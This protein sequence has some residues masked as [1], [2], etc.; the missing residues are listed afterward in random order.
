MLQ[1]WP[2]EVITSSQLD[3]TV[4]L[5]TTLATMRKTRHGNAEWD[6][7]VLEKLG[8]SLGHSRSPESFQHRSVALGRSV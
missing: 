8:M 2:P 5:M 4:D 6:S 1:G 3:K 7:M